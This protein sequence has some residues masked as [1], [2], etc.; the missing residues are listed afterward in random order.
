MTK[1][2]ENL[3]HILR[4]DKD[5]MFEIV[6]ELYEKYGKEIEEYFTSHIETQ[7][8]YNKYVSVLKNFDGSKGGHWTPEQIKEV[9][10]INF[11]EKPY[12]C[13]DFAYVANMRYSDD[14]QRMNTDYIMAS[15]KDYLEDVDYWGDP[16]TRAY[17][18]GK[19]RYEYF[20]KGK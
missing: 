11:D 15:A 5:R 10:K 19:K 20:M 8:A 9:A 2:M 4:N 6:E 1:L 13:Y 7:D 16:S 14:G 18:E 17:C 12:T 3:S